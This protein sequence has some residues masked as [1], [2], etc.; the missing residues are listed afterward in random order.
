MRRLALFAIVLGLTACVGEEPISEDVP[1]PECGDSTP[2]VTWETFGEGFLST[3]C[4]GC[5]ASTTLDRQGAPDGITFDTEAESIAIRSTILNA[6][7]A[8][9]PTMPPNG[10]PNEDDRQ[11]L[12]VWL[13]CWTD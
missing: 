7:A 13:T 5:H 11:L 3:Y 10:G 4:Q 2:L 1:D 9:T 8:T 12:N 6:A